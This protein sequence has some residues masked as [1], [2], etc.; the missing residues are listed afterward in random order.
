[1]L[2]QT[3]GDEFAFD[4]AVDIRARGK[5][6][7]IFARPVLNQRLGACAANGGAVVQRLIQ[8]WRQR[9]PSFDQVGSGQQ[10]I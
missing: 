9:D 7:H 1:M 2:R 4:H 5:L 8:L 6:R 10:F 3:H